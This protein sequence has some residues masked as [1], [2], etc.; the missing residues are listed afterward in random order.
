MTYISEP[1]GV[2]AGIC[3]VLFLTFLAVM[4][5]LGFDLGQSLTISVF[6][7]IFICV[8][9]FISVSIL[10]YF[11]IKN[12]LQYILKQKNKKKALLNDL[13]DWLKAIVCFLIICFIFCAIEKCTGSKILY[14]YRVMSIFP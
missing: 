7:L 10:L 1:T 8:T 11:R 3:L 6:I 12:Y 14:D 5:M 9:L 13:R 2:F 4:S